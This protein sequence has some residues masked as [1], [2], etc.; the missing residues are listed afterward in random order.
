MSVNERE[1]PAPKQTLPVAWRVRAQFADGVQSPWHYSTEKPGERS[2][3]DKSETVFEI[4]P[5]DLQ[6]GASA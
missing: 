4:Q 6:A 2:P 1:E 3:R 5:L